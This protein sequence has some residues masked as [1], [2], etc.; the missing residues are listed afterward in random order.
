MKRE[1]ALSLFFF[2]VCGTGNVVAAAQG[3]F[4]EDAGDCGLWVTARSEQRSINMEN[5]VVGT[6][7]G[8]AIAHEVEFWRATGTPVSQAAIFLWL[9]NYCRT[10]PL[11]SLTIGII[12][13]YEERSGSRLAPLPRR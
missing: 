6:L 3:V 11:E 4:L 8:L 13:L 9:D 7:N 5:Y 1:M 12:S 10:N 2:C